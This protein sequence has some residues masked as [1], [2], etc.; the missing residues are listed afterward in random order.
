MLQCLICEKELVTHDISGTK[1]LPLIDCGGRITI[2]MG[3]GSRFD[4]A[5]YMMATPSE[6]PITDKTTFKR[7]D[8]PVENREMN[9]LSCNSIQAGICDDCF[10]KKQHLF[11]GYWKE[12][13]EYTLIC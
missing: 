4:C 11:K 8:F 6:L 12:N 13:D 1:W 9:L 5:W 2:H 10:E 3:Y 7:A